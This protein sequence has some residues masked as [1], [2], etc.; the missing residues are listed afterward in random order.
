MDTPQAYLGTEPNTHNKNWNDLNIKL[1]VLL[2]APWR[3]EDF[4]GNQTVPLLYQMLNNR[5]DVLCDRAFFPN[6]EKDYKLFRK[7]RIPI[8]GLETKRSM[9]EYDLI[10]TTLSFLPPWVNFPLMLDMS[11]IPS[12]WRD[13]DTKDYP[14]IIVGGS[15]MYGNFSI[16]YPVVNMIYLGDAEP[17]LDAV[18]DYLITHK[19]EAGILYSLQREFGYIF[20]PGCYVPT[21][22]D[23]KFFKW[24]YQPVREHPQKLKLIQQDKLD[25]APLLES[26][27]PSFTDTTM[28]LGEIEIS[29]GC[30]AFCAFCGI[31]WKYKPYR[32]RSREVL[33]PAFQQNKTVS[34]ATALCPIATEFAYYSEKKALIR[35]L[36]EIS[37]TVDPLSMRVDAFIEDEDFD[38]KLSNRG[39]NQLALGVEAPSQRLRNRLGKGITE[40]QILEACAIAGRLK[41]RRLKF[42]MIS[43]IDEEWEDFEEFFNLLRKI[44]AMEFSKGRTGWNLGIICSWT[45]LFVE[46][47][48]PL[49]WKKP[50]IEQRQKWKEVDEILRGELKCKFKLG[51]KNAEDFLWTMQGMHLGDTR[52]A[53]A[54]VNATLKLRRPFYVSFTKKMKEQLTKEFKSTGYTWDYLIRERMPDEVFP[55]D[56]V[57]R[58]VTKK[59]LR[60][61]YDKIVLGEADKKPRR[62]NP[63]IEKC[64]LEDVD[65]KH[66]EVLGKYY[67]I[68]GYYTPE[69]YDVVPNTHFKAVFHR[70]AY[71]TEFPLVVNSLRFFSDRDARNW[72]GGI[73]EFLMTT[74]RFVSIDEVLALNKYLA[75]GMRVC[76]LGSSR[77]KYDWKSYYGKYKV[78]TDV[79]MGEVVGACVE[80]DKRDVVEVAIPSTRYFSGTFSKKKIDMKAEKVYY[81][82]TARG[83]AGK[84]ELEI[85]LGSEVGIRYFLQGLFPH[86]AFSRI[87]QFDVRKNGVSNDRKMGNLVSS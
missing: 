67:H 12:F 73:D 13:R 80:L 31:G 39:M 36:C 18:L 65:E 64:S 63:E 8:F 71:L 38:L 57:K 26:P 41:F 29:R 49:Q 55:W 24:L 44:R 9:G 61:V 30:R 27:I 33:V 51:I 48:T 4:R 22:R 19:T 83:V 11:G 85:E 59:A 66:P 5:K 28:G 43:N 75:P 14:L 56:I 35:D 78:L 42:F 81:K 1:R 34:G 20:V 68:I 16:A 50:T 72:Y 70:A 3:Y 21:Y 25:E 37:H 15:S 17:G 87:L 76:T 52:F 86:I 2:A 10:M 82:V 58:S 54:L 7:Y 47:C 45:P 46:P 62:I 74:Q 60:T 40:E 23:E 53:E 79:G 77:D 69:E 84:T 6:T 32:E